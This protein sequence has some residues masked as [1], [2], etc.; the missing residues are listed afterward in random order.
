MQ[1]AGL[2]C[3]LTLWAEELSHSQEEP[4]KLNQALSRPAPLLLSALLPLAALCLPATAQAQSVRNPAPAQS[5]PAQMAPARMAAADPV[6]MY[7][8]VVEEVAGEDY[9]AVGTPLLGRLT[10]EERRLIPFKVPANG[11]YMLLAACDD[12]CYDIDLMLFDADGKQ[13]E[14]DQYDDDYPV[15]YGDDLKAGQ[16][17]YAVLSMFDCMNEDEGCQYRVGFFAEK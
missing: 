3:G 10:S 9:R 16:T 17:V 8:D 11:N 15:V 7:A 12:D 2:G 13:I 5:T 6:P 14:I 4:M 1:D